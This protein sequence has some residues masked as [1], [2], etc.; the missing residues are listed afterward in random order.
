MDSDDLI[1]QYIMSHYVLTACMTEM[2]SKEEQNWISLKVQS[3][4]YDVMQPTVR[5]SR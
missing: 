3:L 1:V 5:E 2:E 4:Q